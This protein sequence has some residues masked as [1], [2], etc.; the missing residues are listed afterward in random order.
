LAIKPKILTLQK[1]VSTYEPLKDLNVPIV[2]EE[3]MRY[4]KVNDI[5]KEIKRVR[6]IL[7][8]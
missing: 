5:K 7:S 2:I 8:L 3:D 1:T 6:E 4:T